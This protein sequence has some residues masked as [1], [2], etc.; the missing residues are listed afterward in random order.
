MSVMMLTFPHSDAVTS[1]IIRSKIDF[2]LHFS[3]YNSLGKT[4]STI[5]TGIL[6]IKCT[7]SHPR[8]WFK[9]EWMTSSNQNNVV[10]NGPESIAQ[11][12]HTSVFNRDP[13]LI[14]LP[15]EESLRP[16]DVSATDFDLLLVLAALLK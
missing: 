11:P 9:K 10:I 4:I 13:V 14:I 3:C 16:D 5:P 7:H 1:E 6:C 2:L 12:A 15:P 8:K